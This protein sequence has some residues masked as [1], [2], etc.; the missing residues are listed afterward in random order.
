MGGSSGDVSMAAAAS[1]ANVHLDMNESS[2]DRIVRTGDACLGFELHPVQRFAAT[3]ARS[4]SCA[5]LDSSA[6]ASGGRTLGASGSASSL[7]DG[8][9]QVRIPRPVSFCH[10]HP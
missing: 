10:P 3:R 9:L 4:C 6:S 2:W 1:D 8:P 5:P 7:C